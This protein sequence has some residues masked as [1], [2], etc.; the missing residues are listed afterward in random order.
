MHVLL[1]ELWNIYIVLHDSHAGLKQKKKLG[2]RQIPLS[3]K[4]FG[5][6]MESKVKNLTELPPE[7]LIHSKFLLTLN[8]RNYSSEASSTPTTFVFNFH[9]LKEIMY[10]LQSSVS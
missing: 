3:Q 1:T 10:F 6:A 5:S 4:P 8:Q 9:L 7:I 2:G